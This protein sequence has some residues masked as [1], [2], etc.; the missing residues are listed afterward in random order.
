MEANDGI[1]AVSEATGRHQALAV[2]V[3]SLHTFIMNSNRVYADMT[4][5]I[6]TLEATAHESGSL[7][8]E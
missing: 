5:F 3:P 2:E 1:L 6:E 7:D 8:E 4:R